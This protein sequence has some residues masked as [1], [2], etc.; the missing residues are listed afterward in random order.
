MVWE[1]GTL[2][3]TNLIQHNVSS[4]DLIEELT[5][6][7]PCLGANAGPW[8]GL[9]IYRFA[10]PTRPTWEEIR[11]LSLGIVAQGRIAVTDSGKRYVYDQF[12]YLVIS[13]RLQLQSEVLDA[14]PHA[15]CLCLVGRLS[16]RLFAKYPRRCWDSSQY[17]PRPGLRRNLPTRVSCP[18]SMTSW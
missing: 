4:G 3:A 15:P 5:A 7:A 10:E 14:S 13:S 8:P 9:T 17:P 12:S 1:V 11:G 6:R 18:H 2:T 16:L